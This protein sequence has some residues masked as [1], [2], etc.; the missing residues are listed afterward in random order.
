MSDENKQTVPVTQ[1]V[2]VT[3]NKESKSALSIIRHPMAEMERAFEK[4]FNR[5]WPSLWRR[6]DFP[7]MDTLFGD[8]LLE[9]DGQRLP[10]MDVVDREN[11]VLVRAEVPGIE[12][13]I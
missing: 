11:E 5:S 10:N 4:F 13:K 3:E 6:H 1:N 9:F 7:V 12:K 2:P 8:T